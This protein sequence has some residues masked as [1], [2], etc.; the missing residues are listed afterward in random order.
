M[1]RATAIA[2]FS[3]TSASKSERTI[4]RRGRRENR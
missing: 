2:N 4:E 3:G 1:K